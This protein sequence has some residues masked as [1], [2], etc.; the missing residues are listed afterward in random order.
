MDS[1]DRPFV[2]ES[3]EGKPRHRLS[4][5]RRRDTWQLDT[6]RDGDGR[7]DNRQAFHAS[8]ASW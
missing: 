2:T 3:A 1:V 5:D 8:G 4:F 7:Y 6:D